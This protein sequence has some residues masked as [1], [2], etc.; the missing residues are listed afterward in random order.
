MKIL[1]CLVILSAASCAPNLRKE[2][3]LAKLYSFKTQWD[4]F[5]EDADTPLMETS[6][7]DKISSALRYIEPSTPLAQSFLKKDTNILYMNKPFTKFDFNPTFKMNFM[8]VLRDSLKAYL[9]DILSSSEEIKNM[10]RTIAMGKRYDSSKIRNFIKEITVAENLERHIV[11]DALKIY[12]GKNGKSSPSIYAN[13]TINDKC[14]W[15]FSTTIL[16]TGRM[17]I[18]WLID[19]DTLAEELYAIVKNVI[20]DVVADMYPILVEDILGPKCECRRR[21][22]PAECVLECCQPPTN[23]SACSD[24]DFEEEDILLVGPVGEL[25]CSFIDDLGLNESLKLIANKTLT[26]TEEQTATIIGLIDALFKL[27]TGIM[28]GKL[29][30][31]GSYDLCLDT[32]MKFKHW[33]ISG[34]ISQN[35]PKKS[36][37]GRY[38]R[39]G[40]SPTELVRNNS[41]GIFM[42]SVGM[43]VSDACSR[44]DVGSFFTKDLQLPNLNIPNLSI[45]GLLNISAINVSLPSPL[46]NILGLSVVEV[47]CGNYWYDLNTPRLRAGLGVVLAVVVLVILATLY[48]CLIRRNIMRKK[49]TQR[50]ELMRK[51][52]SVATFEGFDKVNDNK[53]AVPPSIPS[54]NS[55]PGYSPV[56][57]D[58]MKHLGGGKIYPTL[59][60]SISTISKQSSM[61]H[62]FSAE[63]CVEPTSKRDEWIDRIE[64]AFAGFSAYSNLRRIFRTNTRKEEI[65]A[66]SGMRVLSYGWIVLGHTFLFGILIT[67]TF[68][69]SNLVS[70][71]PKLIQ[72]FSF[73]A[74]INFHF[75]SDTFLVIRLVPPMAL[76]IAFYGPMYRFLGDGPMF[77]VR[78]TDG[79]N[80]REN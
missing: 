79:D 52:L 19:A 15:D 6:M 38:C 20:F 11:N 16:D 18:S 60:R 45:P 46:E 49:L 5:V 71:L 4:S 47:A 74:I 14:K 80:C 34:A 40:V 39:V 48:D 57:E 67:E 1:F 23:C 22:E 43:C 27:P 7:F 58:D 54:G 17:V 12:L 29:H 26:I 3:V 2:E 75:N 73:Q 62:F 72:R 31:M 44:E 35:E 68:S 55:P 13:H 25:I 66:I 69:T 24:Q 78:I 56:H 51:K 8:D 65:R 33:S 41:V 50:K 30:W 28:E 32:E 21:A 9:S 42:L 77:P 61:V 70:I 36:Y 76:L 64:M 37:K 63:S 59:P 10:I 53:L